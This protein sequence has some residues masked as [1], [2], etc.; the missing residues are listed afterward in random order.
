MIRDKTDKK[1]GQLEKNVAKL[2]KEVKEVTGDWKRVLADYQN[3]VRRTEKEREEVYYQVKKDLVLRFLPILDLLENVLNHSDDEG[4]KLMAREFYKIFEQEGIKAI[5]VVGKEFDPEVMDC[6]EV[7]EG[8]KKDKVAEMV[9]AGYKM[10][11]EVI[12]QAKV[13]VYRDNS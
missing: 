13:K 2:E 5:E 1:T 11:D 7:V 3:L 12:R 9:L 4:I 8:G 6:I 10:G